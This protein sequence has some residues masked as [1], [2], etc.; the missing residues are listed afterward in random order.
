MPSNRRNVSIHVIFRRFPPKFC[1]IFFKIPCS[2][3][4][5]SFF[6]ETFCEMMMKIGAMGEN[7][8]RIWYM[9]VNFLSEQF[10]TMNL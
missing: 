2:W 9:A 8:I 5:K 3:L 1:F 6:H 10:L 7:T 4:F